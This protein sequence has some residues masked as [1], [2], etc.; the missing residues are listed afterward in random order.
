M[1]HEPTPIDTSNVSLPEDLA[2]LLEKLAEHAHDLWAMQRLSEGW[3]YGPQRDDALKRHPCLV[4]YQ[5]LPE[6]EKQYDRIAVTGI[7][8]AI[9]AMG[10][11]RY[12]PRRMFRTN[13]GSVCS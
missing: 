13:A 5:D 1:S 4:P 3:S 7:L 8:K 10:F 6:S 11:Q 2:P 12:P 9:L